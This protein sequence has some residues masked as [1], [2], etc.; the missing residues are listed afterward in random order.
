MI[1]YAV[2]IAQLLIGG[3]VLVGVGVV[4][5]ALA[6]AAWGGL[7]APRDDAHHPAGHTRVGIDRKRN[8]HICDDSCGFGNRHGADPLD[9]TEYRDHP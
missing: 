1:V 4:F 8:P 3:T 5:L 7:R 2:G 6:L 9:G